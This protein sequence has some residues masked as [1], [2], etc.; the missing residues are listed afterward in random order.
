MLNTKRIPES[1]GISEENKFDMLSIV[2]DNGRLKIIFLVHLP[3]GRKFELKT[4]IDK[5]EANSKS[6]PFGSM[7][8]PSEAHG[9]GPR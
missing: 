3:D 7:N 2:H 4:W 8:M 9:E 1:L 6:A 5:Q